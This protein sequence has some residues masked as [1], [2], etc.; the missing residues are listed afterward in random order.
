MTKDQ[1]ISC[2]QLLRTL[3]E[4]KKNAAKSSQVNAV[5]RWT[6]SSKKNKMWK[7]KKFDTYF[8]CVLFLE[9]EERIDWTNEVP[10]SLRFWT[11]FFSPYK[12][13]G[14]STIAFVWVYWKRKKKN[15][16]QGSLWWEF[17]RFFVSLVVQ[18]DQHFAVDTNQKVRLSSESGEYTVLFLS[19]KTYWKTIPKVG[20]LRFGMYTTK[21]EKCVCVIEWIK[22]HFVLIV[23]DGTTHTHFLSTCHCHNLCCCVGL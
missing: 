2:T 21:R 19:C 16:L 14:I 3:H 18:I 15:K 7:I 8:F 12:E 20:T 13:K 6:H 23:S 1:L 22:Q 5:E 4:D 11:V 9:S 10:F 17:Q